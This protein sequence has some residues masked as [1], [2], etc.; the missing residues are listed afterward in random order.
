MCGSL[1]WILKTKTNLH[2]LC[3]ISSNRYSRTKKDRREKSERGFDEKN[4]VYV[5]SGR[6]LLIRQ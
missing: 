2:R 4:I 5:N 3:T 6:K 1:G